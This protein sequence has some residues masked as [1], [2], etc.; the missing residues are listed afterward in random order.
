M[1]DPGDCT[2]PPPKIVGHIRGEFVPAE[3]P[4]QPV[5]EEL[6]ATG[7]AAGEGTINGKTPWEFACDWYS[8]TEIIDAVK[9]NMIGA[10]DARPIPKDVHSEEFGKWMAHEYRL[11]MRKG[12]EIGQ[13]LATAQRQ[14][15]DLSFAVRETVS[16]LLTEPSDP[17]AK[18]IMEGTPEVALDRLIT[19]WDAMER[20]LVER[21]QERDE[22]QEVAN[23]VLGSLE[24]TGDGY[25]WTGGQY[26]Y[27]MTPADALAATQGLISG[28]RSRLVE[29]EKQV[30]E[31]TALSIDYSKQLAEHE[32]ELSKA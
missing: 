7:D 1:P 19:G 29:R 10:F 21:E 5:G 6:P 3:P 13:R 31:L 32:A 24:W 12:I 18:E 23:I 28:L 27:R 11:A 9:Q 16:L 4:V 20:K 30:A 2:T 26:D 14:L 22:S 15:A 8:E 17:I 25:E